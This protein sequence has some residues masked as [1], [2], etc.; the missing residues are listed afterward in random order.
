MSILPG[1]TGGLGLVTYDTQGV[2]ALTAAEYNAVAGNDINSAG[3]T[4]NVKISA[5]TPTE[6]VALA[7]PKTVNSLVID[8]DLLGGT[9]AMGNT[10]TLTSGQLIIFPKSFNAQPYSL[11]ITSGAITAG[12]GASETVDLDMT[13]HDNFVTLAAS[14]L[15]NGLTKIALVKNRSGTLSLTTGTNNTFTGGTFVNEGTLI[16]GPVNNLTYLGTGAVVVDGGAKLVLG[17]SGATSYAGSRA[18]PT[19]T[20]HQGGVLQL[21]TSAPAANEYF[22]VE[23]G[24]VIINTRA[25]AAGG[26]DLNTNLNAAPGAILAETVVGANASIKVGG[27]AIQ[28]GLTT[29]TYFFGIA[30]TLNDNFTSGAGTP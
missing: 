8:A 4:D 13:I 20:V 16:T 1:A 10:L 15:D 7:G 28:T 21:S 5:S 14:V 6:L 9:W 27:V 29:P 11:N 12:S 19:Y 18:A 22:K 24:G 30:S 3:A 25:T 26:L 17:A 2:R 23:S